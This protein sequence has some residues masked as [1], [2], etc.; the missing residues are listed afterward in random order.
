MNSGQKLSDTLVVPVASGVI[1]GA[2]SPWV[3][4]IDYSH[5]FPTLGNINAPLGIG[6]AVGGSVLIGQVAKNYVLP[7]IPRNS[8]FAESE[9]RMLTP[10]LAGVANAGLLYTVSDGSMSIIGK[11]FLVGAGSAVGG[12]YLS[13]T[14][15]KP[16]LNK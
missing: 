7:Y 15:I 13:D 10:A 6:L 4:G 3:Y 8:A 14:W 1:A 2:V 16:F 11:N 9:G 12:S 5:T